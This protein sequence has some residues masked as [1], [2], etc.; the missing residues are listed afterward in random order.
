MGRIGRESCFG[1]AEEGHKESKAPGMGVNECCLP[2]SLPD[3]HNLP[4]F[5]ISISFLEPGKI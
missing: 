5:R 3:L 1:R 4:M 2:G